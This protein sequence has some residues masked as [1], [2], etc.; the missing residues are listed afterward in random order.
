MTVIISRLAELIRHVESDNIKTAIRYEPNF[1]KYVSE[2]AVDRCREAHKPA[3]MN[4]TTARSILKHSFGFYQIM[5]ENIY[6]LGYDKTIF[7]FVNSED[8]Q[9]RMFDKFCRSRGITYSLHEIMTDK[10]KREHFAWRYNGSIGYAETL[11][12]K[13]RKVTGSIYV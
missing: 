12:D 6:S 11:L 4:N 5:G 10:K 3:Y 7:D 8:E 13:Y 2:K 1:E 9:E